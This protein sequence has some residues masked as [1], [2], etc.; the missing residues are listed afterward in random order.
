MKNSLDSI[1][2]NIKDALEYLPISEEDRFS[3][4]EILKNPDVSFEFSLNIK[5]D[6]QI[7]SYKGFRVLHN[8]INGPYK[9]GLRFSQDLDYEELLELSILMTLKNSL[10][11]IPFGGSKGGI[12]ADIKH[13][14]EIDKETLIREYVKKLSKY[15][16]EYTDIPAPDLNTDENDMNIFFDEFSKI[17]GKPVYAIVTGKSED[18]KGIDYRRYSTGYG[19]AYITDAASK[20]FLTKND[21]TVAIQGFGKVGK[22]TFKKLQELGYKIVA[23]SD[24]KGGIYLKEGLD[25]NVL[26]NIKKEYGSVSGFSIINKDVTQINPDEFIFVNCDILIPAA[27]ENVIN[28]S[29]ADKIIAKVIVEGANSPITPEGEEILYKNKKIVIPDILANSGGVYVS[30]FEW[31]K[32][33]GVMDLSSQ[34]I[35]IQMKV[36]LIEAYNNTKN[37]ALNKNIPFRKSAT[38]IALM[39][40]YKKAKLRKII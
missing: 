14:T 23:V 35:D 30:Y 6:N 34:E 25:F 28:K 29:N 5:K 26:E 37:I 31:L 19:V 12:A 18:L 16:D 21:I 2:K 38:I 40:L 33:L 1:F 7:K 27:K 24:S 20:D 11:E 3:L 15:I 17:K 10:L 32:G 39:N 9:G 36:K 4:F 22:Y 13:L 8:S